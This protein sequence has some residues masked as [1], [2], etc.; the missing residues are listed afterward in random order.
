M[1]ITIKI[2]FEM[3]ANTSEL[4]AKLVNIEILIFR[5]FQVDPKEIK[6]PLQWWQKHESMFPTIGFLLDKY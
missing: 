2:F 3:I 4:V 5:T 1:K 6:W